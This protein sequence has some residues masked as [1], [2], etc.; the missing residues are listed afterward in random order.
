MRPSGSCS[1]MF[2]KGW[3]ALLDDFGALELNVLL[4]IPFGSGP[5][6][7]GQVPWADNSAGPHQNTAKEPLALERRQLRSS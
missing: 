3:L 5:L 1:S 6:G 4:N 2:L 7:G